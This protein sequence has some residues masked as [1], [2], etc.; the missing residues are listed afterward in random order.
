[1]A[2][3]EYLPDDLRG[4]IYYEPTDHGSEAAMAERVRI[5]DELLGRDERA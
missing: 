3:Q 4:S 2:R 1:V 5:L